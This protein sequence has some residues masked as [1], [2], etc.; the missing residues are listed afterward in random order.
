MISLNQVQYHLYGQKYP[1]ISGDNENKSS[2]S[3]LHPNKFQIQLTL[4]ELTQF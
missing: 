4:I 1:N 2:F 3:Y